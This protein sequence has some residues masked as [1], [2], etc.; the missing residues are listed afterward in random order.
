MFQ[1][2]GKKEEWRDSIH[3]KEGFVGFSWTDTEAAMSV[4]L[5]AA[6]CTVRCLAGPLASTQGGSYHSLSEL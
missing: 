1:L 5:R 6:P 2:K 4:L 3:S